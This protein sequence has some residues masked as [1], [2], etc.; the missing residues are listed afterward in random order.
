MCVSLLRECGGICTLYLTY[1]TKFLPAEADAF[2]MKDGVLKVVIPKEAP[3]SDF[4]EVTLGGL[5]HVAHRG[6]SANYYRVADETM[7]WVA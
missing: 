7:I 2:G 3:W 6:L 4:P 5:Q 1:V